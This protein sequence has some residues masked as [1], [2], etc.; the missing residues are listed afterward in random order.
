MT[1]FDTGK[2]TRFRPARGEITPWL[3]SDHMITMQQGGDYVALE[4]YARKEKTEK[5]METVK[6][7]ISPSLT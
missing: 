5:R 1:D 6:L 4:R 2:L 3:R 7:R